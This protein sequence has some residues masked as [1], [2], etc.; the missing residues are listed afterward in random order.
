M[1]EGDVRITRR[2]APSYRRETHRHKQLRPIPLGLR[3]TGLLVVVGLS[4]G[5]SV[6]AADLIPTVSVRVLN[7]VEAAA[8]TVAKAEREAGRILRDA[9]LKVVWLDCPVGQ[10]TVEATD[11]CRQPL[12]PTD[13]LL[14]VLSDHSR[15]GIQYESFGFA[16][17]PALASVYYEHAMSLATLNNAHYEVP[18]IL[19]C[20]MAHEIGHLLLGPSSHS[21]CGIMQGQ[22][23]RK[24]VRLIMCGSLHFTVEQSILIRAEVQ[25]RMMLELAQ[26][27]TTSSI[28]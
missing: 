1:E 6:S 18:I 16:V 20:V 25:M 22:W 24:Q 27:R 9:G 5:F 3:T 23:G 19:G 7:Y 11:P 21:E 28:N 26:V 14:R 12:I 10:S 17:A 2:P 15:R 4:C 13:L 8:A